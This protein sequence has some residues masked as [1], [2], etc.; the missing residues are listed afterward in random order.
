MKR[1]GR[2]EGVATSK[3]LA[4][5]CGLLTRG[6]ILIEWGRDARTKTERAAYVIVEGNITCRSVS[7]STAWVVSEGRG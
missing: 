1:E 3:D 7:S 2:R 5:T 4:G 6:V